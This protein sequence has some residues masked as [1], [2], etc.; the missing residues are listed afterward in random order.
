MEKRIGEPKFAMK[1]KSIDPLNVPLVIGANKFKKTLRAKVCSELSF[2]SCG[3]CFCINS[4]NRS[5]IFSSVSPFLRALGT[6]RKNIFM[7]ETWIQ[8][9]L[10]NHLGRSEVQ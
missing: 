2:F 8:F 6:N 3:F 1:F 5:L 9:R 10:I 4:F 7:S